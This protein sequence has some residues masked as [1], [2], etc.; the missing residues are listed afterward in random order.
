MA[1]NAHRRSHPRVGAEKQARRRREEERAAE[2]SMA[3]TGIAL[4]VAWAVALYVWS[5]FGS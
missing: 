1:G 2:L 4:F 5:A 3:L